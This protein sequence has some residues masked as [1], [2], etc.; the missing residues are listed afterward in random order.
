MARITVEDCLEHVNNRFDLVLKASKRARKLAIAG[1]EPMLDWQN[2]KP[3]VM[4]LREIAAG[5]KFA[6][7]DAASSRP[8]YLASEALETVK[9]EAVGVLE[10]TDLQDL[11]GQ[12]AQNLLHSSAIARTIES[13]DLGVVE[14]QEHAHDCSTHSDADEI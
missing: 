6:D 5:Y 8:G 1:V 11:D 14:A 13:E 12:Q 9:I 3:T 7:G 4:A 2:D 10:K